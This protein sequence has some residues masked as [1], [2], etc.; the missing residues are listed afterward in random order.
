MITYV[1]AK[2]LKVAGFPQVWPQNDEMTLHDA[3]I[4]SDIKNKYQ[5]TVYYP[6][7]SELIEACGDMSV[8]VK[9]VGNTWT[10]KAEQKHLSETGKTPEE[11]VARLWLALQK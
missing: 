1:L 2:R 8:L 9:T 11:A 7:L 6:T 4:V 5:G 10:A 3:L